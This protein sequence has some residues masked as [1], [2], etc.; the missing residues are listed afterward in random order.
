M[1]PILLLACLLAAPAL[2]APGV[3]L[4]D[5][6]LRGSASIDAAHV[7]HLARGAVVEIVGHQ[8][9]W[10]QVTGSAGHG[11]VRIL[12][13]R[14]TVSTGAGLSGLVQAGSTRGDSSRV[15]ATA[16]LRGLDEE[17]LKA[18]H[19]DANELMNMDRY[20]VDRTAAE[21]YARAGGLRHRDLDYLPAPQPEKTRDKPAPFGDGG[22]L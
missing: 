16:G 4:K 22:M 5:E 17:Q 2:A 6:D 18:A 7:G 12:S 3:M 15:V 13:V 11:W 19:F 1:K 21:Q 10:T 8:G 20:L 9:G 14:S